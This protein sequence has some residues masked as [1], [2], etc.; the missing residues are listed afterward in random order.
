[1]ASPT[2][3][4]PSAPPEN[5][6][7]RILE[8][9]AL[10]HG[11]HG[12]D[13][14]EEVLQ[15]LLDLREAAAV[16]PGQRIKLL[17][18]LYTHAERVVRAELPRLSDVSLPV[19]RKLRH[20]VRLVLELLETLAQD[21]FNNLA[22][23]FD[24]GGNSMGNVPQASLRRAML[25]IAWQIRIHHL[26]ASPTRPGLWQQLHSAYRTARRFGLENQPGPRG[27]HSIQRLYTNILLSAIAQPASFSAEEQDFISAYVEAASSAPQLTDTPPAHADSTFWIDAERDLP[28]H[29]LVRRAPGSDLAA[30]Y[31]S[32]QQVAADAAAHRQALQGGYTAAAL[33]L[34]AFAD[35]H[36]G[37]GV[38]RRLE[39]LWGNPARR[40]FPRR[41]QSYRA[42]LCCGLDTLYHLM[43][44]PDGPAELSEWMVINESPDGFALMHMSGSTAQLRVGDIV[45]IQAVDETPRSPHGWQ[46][47][48][49]R[50][51]ISENPEHIEIGLQLIASGA[52]SA[53]LARPEAE[54]SSHVAALLLPRMPPLRSTQSLVVPPGVL[55]EHGRR[56]ILLIERDNLEVRE[57]QPAHLDEQ[58]SSVEIFSVEANEDD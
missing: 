41:R 8:W 34:P 13:D 20:R 33:G 19:S 12:T 53:E 28:A 36:A 54:S 39:N 32:C 25:S 57:M 16:S 14:A 43:K 23:L 1:M 46:V 24:P 58:T 4:P 56:I 47:C 48:L 35:S 11:R 49:I 55:H 44:S 40:R 52:V 10:A 2:D 42:R 29:A 31:F 27:G 21:Y 30:L 7:R 3:T 45:A 38:L 9:I 6:V 50:W 5:D 18:L 22:G 26:V 37:Q 15:R 17:D 51:A